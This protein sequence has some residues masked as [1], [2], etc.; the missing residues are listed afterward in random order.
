MAS[1]DSIKDGMQEQGDGNRNSK[2]AKAAPTWSI[3]GWF[4]GPFSW[5]KLIAPALTVALIA[6]M[7]SFTAT[8]APGGDDSQSG[9]EMP[10]LP[11]PQASPTP[12]P[13]PVAQEVIATSTW[14]NF[15]GME[16]TLDGEPVPA[17]TIVTVYDPQGVLCGE[18]LVTVP[19]RYG[20][21]PVYGDDPLTEEDEGALAGDH[22]EFRLNGKKASLLGPGDGIWASM[23]NLDQL[24]L[25][26]AN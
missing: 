10:A 15:Y 19:G 25:A 3:T 9:S 18:F 21:M 22:L 4:R 12:E 14:V 24:E 23:G 13:V 26:G 7:L 20:L 8:L 11:D 1:N 5:R 6:A 16:T 2:T 17:G